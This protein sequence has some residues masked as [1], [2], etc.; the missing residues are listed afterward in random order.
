MATIRPFRAYRYSQK[1][2]RLDDLVTQPYD[3]ITPDMQAR[4][5]AQ[6][7]YNL[8]RIILGERF[9]TDN[10][11]D[12]VYTRAAESLQ[13]WIGDGILVQDPEPAIYAYF[14]EFAVPDTAERLTRRGFIGLGA[15]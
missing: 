14:Q 4:Y 7:P 13:R 15:V 6:S 9:E 5:L 12:N 10:E 3:K 2:G 1:A 11:R 8:V